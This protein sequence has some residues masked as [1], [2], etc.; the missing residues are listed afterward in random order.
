MSHLH[1]KSVSITLNTVIDV[2]CKEFVITRQVLL[3]PRCAQWVYNARRCLVWYIITNTSGLTHGRVAKI[4][5][6]NGRISAESVSKYY[7]S[8]EAFY[9]RDPL[10]KRQVD[11]VGLTLG[12]DNPEQRKAKIAA[13]A[14]GGAA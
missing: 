12:F 4:I 14:A 13:M 9:P 1:T 2:I 7:R 6:T 11:A 8:C 3:R 5:S 10:F